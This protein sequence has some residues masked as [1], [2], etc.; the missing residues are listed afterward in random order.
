MRQPTAA[1]INAHLR[2]GV[3]KVVAHLPGPLKKRVIAARVAPRSH[4][5]TPL[6][7]RIMGWEAFRDGGWCAVE[8][9]TRIDLL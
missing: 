5:K 4:G 6:E 2:T 8:P 1:E 7:V 9:D 3:K